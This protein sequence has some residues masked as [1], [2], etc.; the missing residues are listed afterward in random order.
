MQGGSSAPITPGATACAA[1]LAGVPFRDSFVGLDPAAHGLAPVEH[2]IFHGFIFV[3]L[4]GSGPSVAEM[5]AP[6]ESEIEPYRLEELVP[7]GR[8]TLRPRTVNWKNIGDN[9]SDAL[10][11]TVAHPGLTRLFGRGYGIEAREWVDKMWG[12][13][14]DQ[15]SANWS[16]RIYQKCLPPVPHLPR[17]SPAPMGLLQAVAQR[18][19]RHLSRPGRLHAVRAALAD[20]DA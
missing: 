17:G 10:H 1:A 5:M 8:V 14:R 9:Y 19:V 12:D 16:E 18:R 6:Y 11:I 20:R 13:L 7:L 2:E 15:P 4:A 3:R